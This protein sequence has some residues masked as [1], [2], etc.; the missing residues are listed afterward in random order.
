MHNLHQSRSPGNAPFLYALLLAICCTISCTETKLEA[1]TPRSNQEWPTVDGPTNRSRWVDADLRQIFDR[2]VWKTNVGA[3]ASL[4]TSDRRHLY[5]VTV[6]FTLRDT[7]RLTCLSVDDG[8]KLKVIDAEADEFILSASILPNRDVLILSKREGN[9]LGETRTSRIRLYSPGL[10]EM[11][12][13]KDIP[14]FGIYDVSFSKERIYILESPGPASMPAGSGTPGRLNLLIV[15]TKSGAANVHQA[16]FQGYAAPLA[17]EDGFIFHNDGMGSFTKESIAP[18]KREAVF[19]MGPFQ[20]RPI[21]ANGMQL[22]VNAT[23]DV[24]LVA[25]SPFA[26]SVTR[27]IPGAIRALAA[28]EQL[29]IVEGRSEW[30]GLDQNLAEQWR[31]PAKSKTS[32]VI[33]SDCIAVLNNPGGIE[34]LSKTTGATIQEIPFEGLGHGIAVAGARAF[35]ST[36]SGDIVCLD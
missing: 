9:S 12:W 28:S 16:G 10:K 29:Y 24:S 35:V 8:S 22:V 19:T 15:S 7:R 14:G 21:A 30:I 27:R 6:G 5:A 25:A 1:G 13:S 3:G 36:I 33:G 2:V 4:L 18:D 17:S 20:T 32:V 31:I 26:I 11:R 23:E 34:L